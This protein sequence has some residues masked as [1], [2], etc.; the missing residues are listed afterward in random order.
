VLLKY[1]CLIKISGVQYLYFAFIFIDIFLPLDIVNLM[2]AHHFRPNQKKN[3]RVLRGNDSDHAGVCCKIFVYDFQATA[4][5]CNG[6]Q[7][8]E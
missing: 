4:A 6:S 2:L 5:Y 8:Y 1:A 7:K 3:A